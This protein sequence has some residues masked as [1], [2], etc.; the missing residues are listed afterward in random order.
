MVKVIP[1]G[2]RMLPLRSLQ[3]TNSDVD[4][5]YIEGLKRRLID[6]SLSPEDLQPAH[7]RRVGTRYYVADG[8]HAMTALREINPD[9][10]VFS[11]VYSLEK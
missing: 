11:D 7:I 6:G 3:I 2:S 4:R 9:I 10:E 1:E 5:D 8:N